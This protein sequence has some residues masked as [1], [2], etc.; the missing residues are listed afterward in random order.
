MGAVELTVEQRWECPSCD[1]TD[2][3]HIAGHLSH[4]HPC[5]GQAL[6]M[7]PMVP[8]GTRS[9]HVVAE[10]EDYIGTKLIRCD[11]NG[12]PVTHVNVVRDEGMDAVAYPITAV[13]TREEWE[14]YRA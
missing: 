14:S 6:L 5:R 9:V 8:A 10:F 4:L 7:V 3:T 1:F 12:R 2:V 11:A 13:V